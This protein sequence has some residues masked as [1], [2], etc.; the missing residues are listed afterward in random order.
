MKIIYCGFFKT[1]SRS[2][3]DFIQMA[4]GYKHYIGEDIDLHSHPTDVK[5]KYDV[6]QL[7]PE[8]SSSCIHTGKVNNQEIYTFLREHDDM[9][10]RDFPYFGMYKYIDETYPDSKFI[11]CTRD[12]DSLLKSYVR[13]FNR[14]GVR[15][16]SKFNKAVLG[17]DDLASYE[18]DYEK[19]KSVYETHNHRVLEYFKDRPEKLLKL[20][21]KDIGTEKFEKTILEFIN[22]E[23]TKSFK[24]KNIN[25]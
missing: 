24:M 2:I 6:F 3:C 23:N 4:N 14:M 5:F 17:I 25:R 15:I 12:T 8:D 20:D 18:K 19:I 21:F 7:N 10:A 11:I 13:Y 22:I 1:G 9:I 16:A